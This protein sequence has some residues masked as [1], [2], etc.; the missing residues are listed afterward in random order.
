MFMFSFPFKSKGQHWLQNIDWTLF[1]S[2]LILVLAG[3]FT[4]STFSGDNTFFQKQLIWIVISIFVFFIFSN[5]DFHFLRRSNILIFLYI[6]TASLLGFLFLAGSVFQG[7]RSWF[8]LGIAS[9]QPT[10]FAKLVLVLMLA[11]YFSRRHIEI[12]NIKHI[13][14]SGIY[15]LIFFILVLLQPDFGSAIII[16]LVWLGMVMVSGISRKHLG[17][18]FLAG[19]TTFALLWFYGFESY[20]KQRILTFVHPLADIHGAGYNA[21]Q[22]TVAVGSGQLWGKGIGLGTQSKLQ[23]L[24]EYQT[25]FIFAAFAEE[26]GFVGVMVIFLLFGILIWRIIIHANFGE[27]NFETLYALGLAIFFLTHFVLHVGINV[28][29]LPITGTTIPFISYGGSHLLTEFAGLGILMGMRKYSRGVH[30][31]DTHNEIVGV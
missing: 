27:S 5:I 25:D 9:F 8:D 31:D 10:D 28:G 26:W 16:F 12:A 15:A 14:I 1:S 13:L 6:F 7:A 17:L 2:S 23:F 18:V 30:K 24:P 3:L 22:S 29:L 4:M 21:Y 20:Q 19:I 11:K